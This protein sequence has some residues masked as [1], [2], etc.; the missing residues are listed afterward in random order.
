MLRR[1]SSDP[2]CF[3]LIFWCGMCSARNISRR[4]PF[5]LVQKT[6]SFRHLSK[7]TPT[8]PTPSDITNEQ[9]N[10]YFKSLQ[11]YQN[12]AKTESTNLQPLFI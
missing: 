8:H 7:T 6:I 9:R 5:L 1:E 12:E 3:L 2:I 4:N 10:R 11:F